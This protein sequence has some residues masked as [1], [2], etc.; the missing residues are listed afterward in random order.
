MDSLAKIQGKT[1][2]QVRHD[3]RTNHLVVFGGGGRARW[4]V[5]RMKED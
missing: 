2:K 3:H 4:L 5:V 1:K